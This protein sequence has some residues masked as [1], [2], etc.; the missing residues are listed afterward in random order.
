MAGVALEGASVSVSG[1]D[2]PLDAQYRFRDTA[3]PKPEMPSRIRISHPK[4]G[5]HYYLR[6]QKG[7]S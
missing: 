5:V 1:V 4:H 7:E 2:L 3:S 6:K